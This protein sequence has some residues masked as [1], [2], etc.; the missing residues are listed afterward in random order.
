MISFAGHWYRHVLTGFYGRCVEERLPEH[1]NPE[2]V[3]LT[4]EFDGVE[5]N[6]PLLELE[7]VDAPTGDYVR[8][9]LP[10]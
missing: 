3:S 7:E 9:Y 8:K 4:L 6:F 2:E 10:A 5:Q 1:W